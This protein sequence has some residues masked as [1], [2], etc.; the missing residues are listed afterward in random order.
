MAKK[1]VVKDALVEEEKVKKAK[2]EEVVEEVKTT[3]EESKK[4]EK[5][6][7]VKKEKV[8]KEK[9]DGFFRN[10]Y[11][12]LKKVSWPG[13]GEVFKYSFAVLVFCLIFIGFFKL[14]ELLSA[15]LKTVVS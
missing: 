15:F 4:V 3:K 9:K 6:E 10:M 12:E 8:K 11:K 5:K 2:K 7:K 14:V 1:K 13:A